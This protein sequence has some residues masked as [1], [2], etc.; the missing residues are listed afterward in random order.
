MQLIEENKL[1]LDFEMKVIS[2]ES[3]SPFLLFDDKYTRGI[4]AHAIE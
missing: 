3:V 4:N 1:I 2:K